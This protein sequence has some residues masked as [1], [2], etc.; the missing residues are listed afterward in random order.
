VCQCLEC[1]RRYHQPE[2]VELVKDF[3]GCEEVLNELKSVKGGM[4]F[5][6]VEDLVKYLKDRAKLTR[7]V[8]DV[9]S[10]LDNGNI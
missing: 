4:R 9:E 5:A 3:H 7:I 1:D 10:D 2:I 6:S 8:T